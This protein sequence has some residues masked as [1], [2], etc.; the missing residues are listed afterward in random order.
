M[1]LLMMGAHIASRNKRYV[2]W[3]Y[4]LNLV[5][6]WWG[7]SAFS[8]A[9][10]SILDHSLYAGRIL[11]GMDV[12]VVTELF[13]N[14][15]LGTPAAH[16]A[17]STRLAV[18]CLAVSLVF[19]PG[20]WLAYSS[21]HRISREEFFR[22]CGHNVWRFLRLVCLFIII[23]GIVTGVLF[24]VQ[25][26]LV[27]AADRTSNERLPFLLMVAGMATIFLGATAIRAWFDLAQ[28]DVVLQ[29]QP[30][31]RKSLAAG[32]RAFRQN[33]AVLLRNYVVIV[34]AAGAILVSGILL[35]HA[36][37]PPAS[38]AGAFLISQLTLFLLLA[39][40]FW[41]RATAVAFYLGQLSQTDAAEP[42][43]MPFPASALSIQQ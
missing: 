14:P 27:N 31:I 17:S 16:G 1:N 39:M 19:M 4:L 21:D 24:G 5:F 20:V 37:V 11:H 36:I 8:L 6:A 32:F 23:G 41:Q 38:A 2:V 35:W 7:A 42:A 28:A 9:A 10:H 25:S 22:S 43:R 12:T 18:A 29:D 34:L 15:R 3:F 40:R 33:W 30:A 26:S 13:I